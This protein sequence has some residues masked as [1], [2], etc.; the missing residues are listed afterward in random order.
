MKKAKRA[1][2]A[3][4]GERL[5]KSFAL[6]IS[7]VSTPACVPEEEILA[8]RIDALARR[9]FRD[10]MRAQWQWHCDNEPERDRLAAK[11]GIRL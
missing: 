8:R 1:K 9:A 7:P 4:A 10:G 6:Y 2:K 11:Y 3:T 5:V